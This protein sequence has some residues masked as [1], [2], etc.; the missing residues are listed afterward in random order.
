MR[1]VM[2]W[3]LH[4]ACRC[5]SL[6]RAAASGFVSLVHALLPH[7][8]A[9]EE[10]AARRAHAELIEALW[11]RLAPPATRPA[12]P[13]AADALS[14]GGVASPPVALP[15][16]SADADGAGRALAAGADLAD[17]L[18][19]P[20][21]LPSSGPD[22]DLGLE[23]STLAAARRVLLST[24]MQ[25]SLR[26]RLLQLPCAVL[27]LPAAAAVQRDESW[28]SAVTILVML[29]SRAATH[30]PLPSPG[31]P[32]AADG[33]SATD[34]AAPLDDDAPALAAAAG[35]GG[36]ACAR[37][38]AP[39][40]VEAARRVLAGWVRG[41]GDNALPDA[42]V[43]LRASQ[44]AFLLSQL[45]TLSLADGAL[46]DAGGGSL[47]EGAPAPAN[48][49]PPSAASARS[50]RRAHLLRLAPSLIECIGQP[51]SVYTDGPLPPSVA[52]LAAAV[53]RLLHMVAS[54]LALE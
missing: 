15:L 5:P 2:S 53:R 4:P 18:P 47:S 13:P 1:S 6:P 24:P 21:P 30:Q 42:A 20:P 9:P 31:A 33:A 8:P 3:R 46:P 38:A 35:L 34:V 10:G 19:P 50:G 22:D 29:S 17:A 26:R 7:L 43:G 25:P 54:E 23:V 45:A 37:L 41:A 51:I 16:A 12:L 36:G 49:P 52:E 32:A 11:T 28:R 27:A 39:L 48:S 40:L 44:L 14:L